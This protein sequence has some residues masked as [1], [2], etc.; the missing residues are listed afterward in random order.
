M[1]LFCDLCVENGL[2]N[3]RREQIGTRA[4]MSNRAYVYTQPQRNATFVEESGFW[5]EWT[6][7]FRH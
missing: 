4:I 6:R 3:I 5:I 7:Q 2:R 1:S